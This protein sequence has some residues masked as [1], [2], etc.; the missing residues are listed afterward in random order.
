MT[1]PGPPRKPLRRQRGLFPYQIPIVCAP[2]YGADGR[3]LTHT[4][5]KARRIGGTTAA[6][7]WAANLC[8]GREMRSD[9]TFV[10]REP[11]NV[12]A[13]SKDFKS[14]KGL[15]VE[16]AENIERL[17]RVD[18]AYAADVKAETITFATG[19]TIGA[20]PCSGTAVRSKTGAVVGDEVAFWRQQEEVYAAAKIVANPTGKEPR[21]YPALYITTPWESGSFAHR[22]FTSAEYPFERHRVDIHDAVRAGFPIDPEKERAELGIDELF[23]TEYLCQWSRGGSSFFPAERLRAACR[24]ELPGGWQLASNVFGI[25]VGGGRGRDF[26]ATVRL[27]VIR[28]ELW[29]LG[30]RAYND[31]PIDVQAEDI[32]GWIFAAVNSG[33]A[34][35]RVRVDQGVMGVSL[36][37]LLQSQLAGAREVSIL[38]VGMNLTDQAIYAGALKRHLERGTLRIYTGTDADGDA[39]GSRALM[40]ELARLRSAPGSGGILR[41]TTPRDNKGHCDRA[42]AA[43]IGASEASEPVIDEYEHVAVESR[44]SGTRA[45][46]PRAWHEFA[47]E[48]GTGDDDD[49]P[50]MG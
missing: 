32:A 39:D 26:T 38:G 24:D 6:G 18:P 37:Q 7:Y 40:L 27:A 46:R 22:L 30:V 8:L 34:T 1:Q 2:W 12:W 48:D 10:Q 20:L 17:A 44:W 50:M 3:A 33:A 36:V 14:S 11:M 31:R 19:C 21:G 9:G 13:V 45:D 35:V 43:C 42:W 49:G 47:G 4:L 16:C 29:I 28:G 23:A 41:F 25:D 5:E 15:L